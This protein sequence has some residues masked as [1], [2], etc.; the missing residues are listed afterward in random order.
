PDLL[1]LEHVR[2][3]VADTR[4]RAGVGGR[5]EA[6]RV[7]VEEGRLLGVSDP[8]L[9]VIPAVKRHEVVGAHVSDLR[10]FAGEAGCGEASSPTTASS[11]NPCRSGASRTQNSEITKTSADRQAAARNAG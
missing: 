1:L 8:E 6:E 10:A 3:A 7:L 2:G 5:R 9:D 4:L 11:S